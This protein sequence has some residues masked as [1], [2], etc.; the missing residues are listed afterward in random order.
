MHVNSDCVEVPYR[1]GDLFERRWELMA[2]W[3][4]HRA[5]PDLRLDRGRRAEPLAVFSRTQHLVPRHRRFA[6]LEVHEGH[7]RRACIVTFP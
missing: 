7:L 1:R 2:D 3:A 4:A 6:S 5:I